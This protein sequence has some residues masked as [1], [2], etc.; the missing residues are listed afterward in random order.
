[1]EIVIRQIA[2]DALVVHVLFDGITLPFV[3]DV[4]KQEVFEFFY[5]IVPSFVHSRIVQSGTES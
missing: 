1:M 4:A 5:G 2:L 3:T